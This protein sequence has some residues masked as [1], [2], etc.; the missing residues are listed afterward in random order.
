MPADLRTA[1]RFSDLIEAELARNRLSDEGVN[2]VIANDIT[3]NVM[4]LGL[5]SGGIELLVPAE[6]LDRAQEML[7]ILAKEIAAKKEPPPYAITAELP[8]RDL[9]ETPEE[10]ADRP[11]FAEE[12]IEYA[13]RAAI[14]GYVPI[15]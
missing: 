6:E 14:L 15:C 4:G 3:T 2:A 1:A 5:T 13:Y 12:L 8:P 11:N 9:A 7:D 10:I